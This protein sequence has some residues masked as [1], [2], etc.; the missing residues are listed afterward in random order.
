ME[1]GN[2]ITLRNCGTT[3]E[4]RREDR[5]DGNGL[6]RLT[7]FDLGLDGGGLGLTGATLAVVTGRRGEVPRGLFLPFCI[8]VV[9]STCVSSL[10]LKTKPSFFAFF[11][12]KNFS[13]ETYFQFLIWLVSLRIC[14][15]E[16]FF[17]ALLVSLSES[18]ASLSQFWL[19]HQKHGRRY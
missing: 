15:W 18:Q 16:K 14:H 5:C 10:E 4:H 17:W 8:I 6:K 1:K 3:E 9:L 2:G 11:R 12:N 7:L 19:V 13:K